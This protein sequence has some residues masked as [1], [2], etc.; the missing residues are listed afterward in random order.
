MQDHYRVSELLCWDRRVSNA[1]VLCPADDVCAVLAVAQGEHLFRL[2][3][4]WRAAFSRGATLPGSPLQRPSCATLGDEQPAA[5]ALLTGGWRDGQR[6]RHAGRLFKV[7][8]AGRATN[9]ARGSRGCSHV[10]PD[11]YDA[12]RGFRAGGTRPLPPCYP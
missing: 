12:S 2:C 10:G 11:R 3:F 1:R 5:R 6:P 8:A 7:Q 9:G 4:G